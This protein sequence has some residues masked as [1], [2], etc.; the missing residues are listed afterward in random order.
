[1]AWIERSDKRGLRQK[2]YQDS[3]DP[4]KF[5]F[6]ATIHDQHY[7]DDLNSWQEVDESLADDTTHGYVKSCTKTRHRIHL[8]NGGTRR[9]YPRRNI[10]TEYV[11]ITNIQYWRTTGGGSWR[12]LNLPTP[13]WR[14]QGADWDLPNLYASIT[15][16]W[17]RIK[18]DFILKDATAP[19]RLRFAITLVGLTLGADWHLRNASDEIAG[20]IDP[21][22]AEDANE[23][24]VT[25][26]A[27]Y[28]GGYVEWEVVPGSA[29]YPITVDPVF[30]DGDTTDGDPDTACDTTLNSSNATNNYGTLVY[31]N[32]YS[33]DLLKFDF[34]SI[35][36]TA[37][38]TDAVLTFRY[39]SNAAD[40]TTTLYSILSANS[41]WIE[42]TA[43]GTQAASGEPC[44]DAKVAN[45]SGGITT[46]W[47]GDASGDGGADAGCSQSGTDYNATSIGN[48]TTSSTDTTTPTPTSYTPSLNTTVVASWFG[49]S[50]S[51]YGIRMTKSAG[52]RIC[53]SDNATAAN[54]PKL[55]VT[56]TESGTAYQGTATLAAG[57]SVAAGGGLGLFGA[58]SLAAALGLTG[59]GTLGLFG[60][61]SLAAG[62]STTANGGLGLFGGAALP[63]SAG[64]AAY[65]EVGAFVSAV[66]ASIAA[67][68]GSGALGLFGAGTL[69]T[70]AGI[71]AS[72][73]T[74][75]SVIELVQQKVGT[76]ATTT[77]VD[78]ITA[79][80]LVVVVAV[81]A[82]ITDAI[83]SVTDDASG[84]SNTYA[85]AGTVQTNGSNES[86]DIWYCYNAKAATQITPNFSSGT[87]AQVNIS[88]WQGALATSSVYGGSTGAYDSASSFNYGNVTPSENGCLV[89]AGLRTSTTFYASGRES[90]WNALEGSSR[91]DAQY[92]IQTTAVETDG[93]TTFDATETVTGKIAWFKSAGGAVTAYDGT[94]TLG[95]GASVTASGGLGV[96]GSAELASGAALAASREELGG[97]RGVMRSPVFG[98]YIVR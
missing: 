15:N 52:S 73:A 58:G 18:T 50:N 47:A 56:Y 86:A 25:V 3:V 53:S 93:T 23:A 19:T 68:D 33:C 21:P 62:A 51:N 80:N 4:T 27:T 35:A 46:K 32:R 9:W 48:F 6:V 7:R 36:A 72:R 64:L 45:G 43:G 85:H 90:G 14:A 97:A 71:T 92:S 31:L 66:L 28:A 79:G 63:A 54:R 57:A 40:G 77:M 88:E 59:G 82:N 41:G 42:G 37:T 24:P 94:A 84:G 26:T 74:A 22:V 17:R 95:I 11:E 49:A 39:Y 38:C 5:L 29:V 96:F 30:T 60:A 13:V 78:A 69:G 12:N 44:W 70:G 83:T 81:W 8:G 75:G 61:A 20:R 10:S 2:V 34:S 16:T 91:L 98:G 55:A 65:S 76:T 67:T 87:V 89:I 1:M